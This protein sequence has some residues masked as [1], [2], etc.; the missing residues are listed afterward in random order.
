MNIQAGKH[1]ESLFP[2]TFT[3]SQKND[4]ITILPSM[5]RLLCFLTITLSI[6]CFS[7][8][9][10]E[11]TKRVAD[12]IVANSAFQ[13]KLE[14]YKPSHQLSSVQ[15]I[16]FGRTFGMAKN[17]AAFAYTQI[18]ATKDTN[19]NLDFSNSSTLSLWVNGNKK[20]ESTLSNTL[21]YRF[22]ER[23]IV[24]EK[25][26]TIPLKKGTNNL[27]IKSVYTN[28]PDWKVL[29]Q[30]SD[31]HIVIGLKN[32]QQMDTA[33]ANLSNFLVA[34]GFTVNN[35]EEAFSE[36]MEATTELNVA[37]V[38]QHNNKP[39]TW[40][41][42]KIE[43]TQNVINPQPYW[44]SFYNYNY[45]TAGVAWA[46][47]ELG[48]ITKDTA[49]KNYTSNYCNFV[50]KAKPFVSYQVKEL[51][52]TNSVDNL[53]V[54]TPLLDF[55]SAPAMPFLYKLITE[56]SF[57]NRDAYNNFF[58]QIKQYIFKQQIRL[59]GGN[60]TRETPE[61]YTTWVDDMFMGLPFVIHCAEEAT[62]PNEKKKYE[63]DAARQ[64]L[65]FSDI[66][67]DKNDSLFHHARHSNRPE[68]RYP[69]WLRAN[70]WGLWAITEVL[71][72]LPKNHPSYNK[73]MALY[74][75][76]ITALIKL[77]DAGGMWHN[78]INIPTAKLETSGSAIITLAIARG[79][80][81]GWLDKNTYAPIAQKAWNALT[82]NI[83]PDGQ[84]KNIIVGSFTS[85]DY[86][87]YENQPFVKNDSHG[88]L[89][90]LMCGIEMNKLENPD[91]TVKN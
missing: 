11:I 60:F 70:G 55:T 48:N 3:Y 69:Y 26:I 88:M 62:D 67:F 90:V 38:Y 77:Q 61:K 39:F 63:D 28:S 35:V 53:I 2:N 42:P 9:P 58:Q 36:K 56:K 23:S 25:N 41:L 22:L 14:V 6:Q 52:Q 37:K 86:R 79:V 30:C 34:G 65:S 4:C 12:Y 21:K 17:T 20:Y 91:E 27:L 80:N 83:E 45:H 15:A 47:A 57:K 44:G 82:R 68:V 76:H 75:A 31:A 78:I 16:D 64:V 71:K 13:Y 49:Y 1:S 73:I 85:E 81:E 24:L 43:L 33:T 29:L 54:N 51:W 59:P 50:L 87:Y 46:I 84:V 89:C 32:M 74:K 72:G 19:I 5:K 40:T 18:T 10:I 66:L 8:T 7:Q